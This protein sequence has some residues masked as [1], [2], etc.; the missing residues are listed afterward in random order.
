MIKKWTRLWREAHF[1]VKMLK[2]RHARSTFGSWDVKKVQTVVA[3]SA[4]R[5]WTWKNTC[6]D[7]FLD[8]EAW[9]LY[10]AKSKKTVR[11]ENDG[12]RA[13]FEE[14]LLR[15]IS[16]GRRSTTYISIRDVRRSGGWFPERGCILEHQIVNYSG[17]LWFLRDRCNAS[18]R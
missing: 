15:C 3:Q 1:Q 5:S 14:G 2:A 4:F 17:L 10:P 8:V 6:S 12:R 11:F 13:T 7:Y 18:Y 16:H 9:V